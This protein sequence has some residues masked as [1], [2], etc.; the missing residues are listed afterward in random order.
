MTPSERRSSRGRVAFH[1]YRAVAWLGRALPEHTGR[2]LFRLVR[3][4][5]RTTVRTGRAG[6]GRREPGPG[7]RP[8]RRRPARA[9]LDAG[10]VR[11][12]RPLLVRLVPRP[13]GSRSTSSLDRFECVGDREH[14][15]H[16]LAAGT[17]VIVALPH[18]GNW[19]VAAR[20]LDARG[21]TAVAVAEQ[22]DR[23][24]CSTCS[25]G[26]ARRSGCEVIGLVRRRA[27]GSK[28]RQALADEPPGR[29]RRRPRSD[30]ARGRGR[31]VR[32]ARA[33]SRPARRCSRSRRAR[34][35]WWRP[36]IRPRTAGSA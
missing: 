6:D 15:R 19:D 30:R 24:G 4:R 31:D 5:W 20:W 16:A 33:G 21:S 32:R 2:L 14:R 25:C 36:S 9:G 23:P 12:L 17:G 27:S 8:A 1:A 18:I 10:G 26:T 34:P 11:Q 28:L 3:A 35:S 13:C 29:A 22:L 7:A